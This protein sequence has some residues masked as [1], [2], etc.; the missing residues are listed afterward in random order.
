[1]S[2]LQH[3]TASRLRLAREGKGLT[4][5]QLADLAGLASARAV[6]GHETGRWRQLPMRALWSLCRALDE[7][8]LA[9][10]A[11]GSWKRAQWPEDALGAFAW[12]ELVRDR[13]REVRHA[14]GVGTKALATDAD[15]HQSWIVRIESGEVDTIDLLRLDRCAQALGVPLTN[16]LIKEKRDEARADR[17]EQPGQEASPANA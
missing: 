8:M 2:R 15:V 1:M 12:T 7:D 4:L 5:A 17:R 10:L 14:K 9:I 13:L 16:L 6:A 3:R 11:S